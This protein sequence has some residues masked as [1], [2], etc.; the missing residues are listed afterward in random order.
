LRFL[1][2]KELKLVSKDY[3]Y[4]SIYLLSFSDK[5]YFF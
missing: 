2:M 3:N 1:L 5:I 4:L